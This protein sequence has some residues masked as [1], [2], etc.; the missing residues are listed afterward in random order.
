MSVVTMEAA[1]LVLGLFVWVSLQLFWPLERGVI[2]DVH[3]Y[4]IQGNI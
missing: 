2:A 4:L 3:Q 1:I